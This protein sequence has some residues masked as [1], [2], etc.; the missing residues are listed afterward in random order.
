MNLLLRQLQHQVC[1]GQIA[2]C[3]VHL[4]PDFAYVIK[5]Q[6]RLDAEYGSVIVDSEIVG[7]N[8]RQKYTIYQDTLT[9]LFEMQCIVWRMIMFKMIYMCV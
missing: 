3:H 9:G 8:V 6:S 4:C 7:N 2:I 5:M 1:V